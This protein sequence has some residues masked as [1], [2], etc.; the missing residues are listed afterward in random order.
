[1]TTN[2]T[3]STRFPFPHAE[4][5]PIQ[6]GKPT[7]ITVKQLQKEVFA[8]TRAVH[9]A[10]NGGVNGYLGIAMEPATYLARAG[11]PF[12]APNHPEDQPVHAPNA[13]VAQIMATNRTYDAALAEFRRYEEIREAIRQQIL[14][15]VEATTYHDV[16]ANEDFGYT[17]VAIP[18]I[19]THL[20]RTTYATLTDDD[21]ETTEINYPLPGIPTSQSS[22]CGYA[23][24]TFGQSP[25]RLGGTPN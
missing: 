6:Q 18:Q 10:R 2:N 8:N 25:A 19:L 17:N 4:L 1:M 7:A 14:Q 9:S 13:T 24:N 16:L 11:V 22:N 21:L 5:T 15:A 23:S 20:V 3:G 12:V